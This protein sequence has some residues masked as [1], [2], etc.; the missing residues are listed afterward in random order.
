MD[1]VGINVISHLVNHSNKHPGKHSEPLSS[2]NFP[3]VPKDPRCILQR[4]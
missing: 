4:E 1:I 2:Y 3:H